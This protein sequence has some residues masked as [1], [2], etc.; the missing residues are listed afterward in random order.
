MGRAPLITPVAK[1]IE[2]PPSV[3]EQQPVD[4]A[5]D[6]AYEHDDRVLEREVG[7]DERVLDSE[8]HR[9]GSREHG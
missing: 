1:P 5:D 8:Q 9:H 3:A 6:D 4:P 7:C 2:N